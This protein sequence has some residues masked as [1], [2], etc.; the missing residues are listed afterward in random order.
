MPR[1]NGPQGSTGA[2][3]PQGWPA[4]CKQG[5]ARALTLCGGPGEAAAE[6]WR[7][8]DLA[9]RLFVCLC[10]GLIAPSGRERAGAGGSGREG[11]RE[12]EREGVQRRVAASAASSAS[13]APCAR[14][15]GT[16]FS[17]RCDTR[18]SLTAFIRGVCLQNWEIPLQRPY[19]CRR[20]RL[21]SES[22]ATQCHRGRF[23][24]RLHSAG[25]PAA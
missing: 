3:G 16:T 13:S 22:M 24:V 12:R 9:V 14:S 15:T 19:T 18:H 20:M 6:L 1:Q 7:R 8:C 11:E 17:L 4:T 23:A 2:R 25:W 21:P 10:S 5:I